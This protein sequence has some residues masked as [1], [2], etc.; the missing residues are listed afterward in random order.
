M[1]IGA[2]R[3]ALPLL[4]TAQTA[5]RTL[6]IWSWRPRIRRSCLAP[7]QTRGS[8]PRNIRRLSIGGPPGRA[9]PWF[10]AQAVQAQDAFA[11]PCWPRGKT[12]LSPASFSR[13][14]SGDHLQRADSWTESS[15]GLVGS[16][17]GTADDKT[18]TNEK[19]LAGPPAGP[20]TSSK[21]G[22]ARP[23]EY[24][25]NLQ[26]IGHTALLSNEWPQAE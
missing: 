1:R 24:L 16:I 4:R 3:Y 2:C 19:R 6:T 12:S 26:G 18:R 7:R 13:S 15:P 14:G 10:G 11:K 8:Q 9:P 21:K 5:R 23:R 22:W 17:Q 25:E 20:G